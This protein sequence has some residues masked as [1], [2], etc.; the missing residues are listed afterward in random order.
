MVFSDSLCC[1]RW[2]QI[3]RPLLLHLRPDAPQLQQVQGGLRCFVV[4]Y[5]FVLLLVGFI[6]LFLLS[7]EPSRLQAEDN[8]PS[9]HLVP[10]LSPG[11]KLLA[12][13]SLQQLQSCFLRYVL[14]VSN[15]VTCQ[16][17]LYQIKLYLFVILFLNQSETEELRHVLWLSVVL[18][19]SPETEL[20]CCLMLSNDSLYF[21]L[22][23]SAA[24]L[25]Q[26]S[27]ERE[28]QLQSV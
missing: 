23:D 14:Q 1:F 15:T 19:K 22:E 24:A 13:L 25:S 16:L 10:G 3:Q 5:R 28:Q 18:Y 27:G 12:G 20:T 6:L 17:F 26:Q 11:L 8:Q 2:A 21:L 7:W 4:V 9:S